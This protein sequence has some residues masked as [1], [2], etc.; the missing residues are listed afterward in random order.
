[1]LTCRVI[2]Q[3]NRRH[4]LHARPGGSQSCP[5]QRIR[6]R[7]LPIPEPWHATNGINSPLCIDICNTV[8]FPRLARAV[9]GACKELKA[10]PPV[11]D[12][13]T[14]LLGYHPPPT[15]DFEYPD[16]NKVLDCPKNLAHLNSSLVAEET[17][18]AIEAT[19]P[20]YTRYL[21][22]RMLY[23]D[24]CD[25]HV[26]VRFIA[27][28]D[29]SGRI[30]KTY[31]V[32][33]DIT[34]RKQAEQERDRLQSQLTQ[35]QKM[36]SVGRLAGGV[37]H[38]FNNMLN[39]ILGHAELALDDLP[40]DSPLHADLREIQAAAKRSANLTHQ[41]LAFA[42]KQTVEPK[43]LDLNQAVA[44]TLKMLRR[45]V[46][47][48]IDL[49]WKPGKDVG[50]IRIDP[51]QVDQL[52]ANLCVNARDAIPDVGKITIETGEVV[53]DEE[54]CATHAGFVPGEYV[55]L[56]VSD[57]GCGMSQETLANIF[58]PFF[59]TKSVSEGTGLGLATVYGIVKQ[60]E[61]LINV[62]S[63]PGV[64]TTFKI[65][66]PRHVAKVTT[67][68][69]ERTDA[70]LP[71]GSETI[72]LVEDEP[73][74]LKMTSRMLER[75]GY[76]VLAASTPSEAI[77]MAREHVGDIDL[78]MTD[79]V[80]PEMN[81]RD[82]AGKILSVH[83]NLKRLFMSGYTANVIAHHGVLDPGVDFLQK[84]F[85]ANELAVKTRE[86]LDHA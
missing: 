69:T 29:E 62:Y 85:S 76:T 73:S 44:F 14:C 66:L 63:E 21:E 54:Y 48:N 50:P 4:R 37:A 11:S 16:E 39:V 70:T 17:R 74:I 47:E 58:E 75:Q 43:S 53:F 6:R 71:R 31:G 46:G 65:Y 60:N 77:R 23:A 86:V 3:G 55:L 32:N 38:D 56:A 68:L 42:R 1:M 49:L 78:L 72:L 82:L 13:I 5:G 34:E 67:S 27:I 45:L 61:G 33:Q 8:F 2:N 12:G 20:N 83:P 59:T 18:K 28:K 52:L 7:R 41:L 19:E 35:A 15:I 79:V 81:G 25:G 40:Q 24:G 9:A 57:D 51:A 10:K 80:M 30:V 26:A 64:G 84:P 22:H 36:E